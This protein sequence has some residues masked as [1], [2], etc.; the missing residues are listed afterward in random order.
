MATIRRPWKAKRPSIADHSN[1]HTRALT[2]NAEGPTT[3]S[4]VG[5]LPPPVP[6]VPSVILTNDSIVPSSG[7]IPAAGT[8]PDKLADAWDALKADPKFAN[9]SRE[10]DTVGASSAPSFFFYDPLILDSR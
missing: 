4:G 9:T 3:E 10:L 2:S 8:V 5:E 7:I 1:T 6:A